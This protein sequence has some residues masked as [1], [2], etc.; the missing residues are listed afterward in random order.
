LEKQYAW[1]NHVL[2]I[3]KITD[4]S[5]TGFKFRRNICKHTFYGAVVRAFASHQCGPGLIPGPS[6]ICLLL[7][8]VLA[9]RVFLRVLQFSSLHKNQHFSIPIRSG[10]SG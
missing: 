6:I 3:E 10:N 5:E 1:Q 2:R 9:L 4:E 7:V 8:L